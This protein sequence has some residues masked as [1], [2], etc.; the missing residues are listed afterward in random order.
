MP[1]FVESGS[2]V[3]E[4]R[5]FPFIELLMCPPPLPEYMRANKLSLV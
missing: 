3:E 5:F 1:T 2:N 4:D